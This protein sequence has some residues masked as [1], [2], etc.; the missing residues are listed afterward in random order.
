MKI[1][2]EGN[3]TSSPVGAKAS[4]NNGRPVACCTCIPGC[5]VTGER[6]DGLLAFMCVRLNV[7]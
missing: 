5:E 3:A 4:D 6:A 1:Y 2:N 7:V